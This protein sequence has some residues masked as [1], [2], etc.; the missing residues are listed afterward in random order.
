VRPGAWR[1]TGAALAVAGLVCA[2][3]ALS[4]GGASGGGSPGPVGTPLWSPRRVPGLVTDAAGA[5]RLQAAL[6][7]DVSGITSSCFVVAEGHQAL[8]SRAPDTALL[9]AST[10]KLLTATAALKVLGPDFHYETK[11]V[12]A[13]APSGGSVPQLWLVGAGDPVLAT[14][15]Y[16]AYLQSQPT[17]RDDVVTTR[18]EALADGIVSQ[19]VRSIPGGVVGDDSRYDQQRY[20]P[21]WEP[22][23]RTEPNIGPLG[24]LTVNGGYKVAG[25]HP[26]PVDD[27]ALHAAQTLTQLLQAR[28]VQVG[29][30][31]AHQAAPPGATAVASVSSPSLHDILVSDLRA[32]NNLADELLVKE[33]GVRAAGQGTTVAGMHEVAAILQGL[34]IPTSGLNLV[35]GSGLDRGNRVRCTT[36]AQVLDLARQP[37]FRTV[38]DGLPVAGE[39]GTLAVRLR[40]TALAGK[41]RAKTG[42]LN[43]VSGLAGLLDAGR[44]LRFV[45]LM[46]GSLT[47]AQDMDE[48]E[49]FASTLATFP[50]APAGLVPGP[51]PP[52]P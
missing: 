14:A 18:L 20:L 50:D 22:S 23:Y 2:G 48:R 31:K 5:Q 44:P 45:V 36:L 10:E 47:L 40:G 28:G 3:L 37:A 11:A 29:P 33:L 25:G 32:S 17:T 39:S 6:D 46:N 21:T 1:L 38:L 30:P 43:G 34:G 24:A 42:S 19:G 49:R 12:A 26:A 51:A 7:A 13:P 15:D 35:D 27:P 16:V 8:A 52:S 41:L 4:G 9:P